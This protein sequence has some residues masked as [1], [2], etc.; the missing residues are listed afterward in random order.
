VDIL[1]PLGIYWAI[2]GQHRAEQI[3]EGTLR[4]EEGYCK[5][6]G[7]G[8]STSNCNIYLGLHQALFGCVESLFLDLQECG[9]RICFS[10]SS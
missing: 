9:I 6:Q 2:E 4:K 5:T 7:E 10:T 1:G 8:T 3:R